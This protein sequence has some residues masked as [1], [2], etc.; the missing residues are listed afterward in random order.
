MGDLFRFT[1][2]LFVNFSCLMMG[3]SGSFVVMKNVAF[4]E[5]QYTVSDVICGLF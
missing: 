5:H 2:Y 4:T 1:G 3:L